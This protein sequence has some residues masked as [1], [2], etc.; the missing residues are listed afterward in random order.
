MT[1]SHT[2]PGGEEGAAQVT[3]VV[4]VGIFLA[5]LL[6]VVQVVVFLFTASVAQAAAVDGASRGAGAAATASEAAAQAHAAAVLG[7]LTDDATIT[8]VVR[9]D[10]SGQVLRV[11]VH[12][13]IPTVL[14]AIGLAT[15]ERGAEARIEQ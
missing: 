8:T 5:F 1:T 2:S 14:G 3:S 9:D 7:D 11:D 6:V 4:G 13:R 10:A 15:V 12:V